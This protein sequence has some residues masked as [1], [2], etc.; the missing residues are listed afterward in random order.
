MVVYVM[1]SGEDGEGGRVRRVYLK[2][3][4]AIAD[5][6]A[7]ATK[8]SE[9]FTRRLGEGWELKRIP[10]EDNSSIIAFWTYGCDFVSVVVHPVV[11]NG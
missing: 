3:E 7:Y 10:R 8:K 1:M 4:R 6:K 11:E 5:A 2:R 9:E